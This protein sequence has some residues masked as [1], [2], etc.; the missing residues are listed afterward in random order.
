MTF[1]PST[2]RIIP[3]L[4]PSYLPVVVKVYPSSIVVCLPCQRLY[5]NRND[6]I[7]SC[8]LTLQSRQTSFQ[9]GKNS[10]SKSRNKAPNLVRCPKYFPLNVV[11]NRVVNLVGC[12]KFSTKRVGAIPVSVENTFYPYSICLKHELSVPNWLKTTKLTYQS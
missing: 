7:W 5:L 12:S 1:H 8:F 11:K 3:P 2:G 4:R 9:N 10:R 6:P